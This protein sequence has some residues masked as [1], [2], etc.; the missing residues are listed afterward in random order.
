MSK[1]SAREYREKHQTALEKKFVSPGQASVDGRY[2]ICRRVSVPV[3]NFPH[4]SGLSFRHPTIEGA[5]AEAEKNAARRPGEQ[6]GVF[7]FTGIVR[8]V[9]S[10]ADTLVEN[11]EGTEA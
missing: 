6:F 7:E 8:W 11:T 1:K 3:Q 5:T 2:W 9:E 10:V 4:Y